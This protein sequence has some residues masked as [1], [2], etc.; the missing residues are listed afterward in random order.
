MAG[1][2]VK[3]MKLLYDVSIVKKRAEFWASSVDAFLQDFL[4]KATK[5]DRLGAIVACARLAQLGS[6][7]SQEYRANCGNLVNSPT[8]LKVAQQ[9]CSLVVEMVNRNGEQCGLTKAVVPATTP[10]PDR[11][12]N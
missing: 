6:A 2:E 5:N 4:D 8:E 3:E 1:E 12:S 7:I 11:S 10:Q 9:A